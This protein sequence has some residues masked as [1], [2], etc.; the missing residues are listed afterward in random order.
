MDPILATLFTKV[1]PP[2]F[3]IVVALWVS[4]LRGL[5]WREDIRLVWP[6]PR[7]LLAWLGFWVAW[8][9][10]TEFAG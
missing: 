10:V 4:R 9:V 7:V 5:S 3:A 8:M 6:R 1:A 2:V